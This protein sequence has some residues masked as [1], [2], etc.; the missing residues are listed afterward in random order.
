MAKTLTERA[1]EAYAER[2]AEAVVFAG[3]AYVHDALRDILSLVIP[4]NTSETVAIDGVTF[5]LVN[6]MLV[7]AIACPMCGGHLAAPRVIQD[8]AD[9]GALLT[10]AGVD[11]AGKFEEGLYDVPA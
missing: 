6:G 9:V 5:G 10:D 2:E 4:E 11:L 7:A 8:M 1:L 3:Y